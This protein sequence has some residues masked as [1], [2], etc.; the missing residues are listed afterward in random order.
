MNNVSLNRNFIPAMLHQHN[1]HYTPNLQL[2]SVGITT[3]NHRLGGRSTYCLL[4]DGIYYMRGVYT[5][6]NIWRHIQLREF[7]V[8]RII[9]FNFL[10]DRDDIND[11]GVLLLTFTQYEIITHEN[12]L[13]GEAIMLN[14]AHAL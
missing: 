9:H 6:N 4:T 1:D 8:I 10:R 7:A 13:I 2:V 14:Q 5:D 3:M 12:E 11:G